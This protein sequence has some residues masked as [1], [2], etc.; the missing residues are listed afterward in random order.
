MEGGMGETTV[1]FRGVVVITPGEKSRARGLLLASMSP[2]PKIF[3]TIS[4]NQ[5][6]REVSGVENFGIASFPNIPSNG[7]RDGGFFR[8]TKARGP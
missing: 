5:G 7:G 4:N 8:R 1:K 3:N 2:N 6:E